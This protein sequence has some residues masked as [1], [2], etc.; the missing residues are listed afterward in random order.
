[1]SASDYTAG[2]PP[3]PIGSVVRYETDQRPY[4][5]WT[6]QDHMDP[7]KHPKPPPPELTMTLEVAYPDGVAYY[8]WPVGVKLKFGNRDAAVGWVR[9]ERFT[10]VQRKDDDACGA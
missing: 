9:R 7:A 10:V 2:D 3:V 4:V 8:L 5:Y 1:M 6:I